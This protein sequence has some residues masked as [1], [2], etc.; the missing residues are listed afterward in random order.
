[1]LMPGMRER[2]ALNG[3]IGGIGI[4]DGR[5]WNKRRKALERVT[6]VIGMNDKRHRNEGEI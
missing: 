4:S 1:M 5:H 6:E 2:Y 3:I